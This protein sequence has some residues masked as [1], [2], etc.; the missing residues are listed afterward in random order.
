MRFSH[1]VTIGLLAS[2]ATASSLEKRHGPSE[3]PMAEPKSTNSSTAPKAPAAPAAPAG[4]K[5]T[6]PK[7]CRRLATDTDWPAADVW[8]KTFPGILP[9]QAAK[10]GAPVRPDYRLRAKSAADVEKAVKFA[11][12]NNLRLTVIT[13]GHDYLG[14]NDAPSGLAVDV[15]LLKGIQMHESFTP[16]EKGL[17]SAIGKKANVIDPKP[18][19]QPVVTFG[20][21][22]STQSL[23]NGIR[24]SKV[25][26]LGAGHGKSRTKA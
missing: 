4:T 8:T 23:N 5:T 3:A 24:A 25:F 18:G 22:L 11:A 26:T 2:A 9:R 15:S 1:S 12:D 7:G 19:S 16:T 13:T 10:A 6:T 20:V 21:G 14:R 17:D